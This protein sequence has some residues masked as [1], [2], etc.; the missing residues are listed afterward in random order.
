MGIQFLEL[1]C[2]DIPF[3][4]MV[5]NYVDADGL[6]DKYLTEERGWT[7]HLFPTTTSMGG[8]VGNTRM[9]AVWINY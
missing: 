3:S 2:E 1:I 4:A 5:C 9:E 7:K 8:A 6:Y